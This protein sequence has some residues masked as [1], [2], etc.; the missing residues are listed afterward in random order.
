MFTIDPR[1]ARTVYLWHLGDRDPRVYRDEAISCAATW[2]AQRFAEDATAAECRAIIA[3][4]DPAQRAYGE[5][6]TAPQPNGWTPH[7]GTPDGIARRTAYWIVDAAARDVL[8]DLL[9]TSTTDK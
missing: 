7:D 8:C 1:T 6:F 5:R 2:M 4:A 3:A 9:L